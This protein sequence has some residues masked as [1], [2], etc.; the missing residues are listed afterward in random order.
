MPESPRWLAKVGSKEEAHYILSR[1]R[2]ET[3][4]DIGKAEA[5]FQD[6]RNISK[7]ETDTSKH[8]S[9]FAMFSGIGSAKL[10]TA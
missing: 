2:G 8:Q 9:Y 6:I 5:E 10:D 1:L 4:A 3:G 7:L